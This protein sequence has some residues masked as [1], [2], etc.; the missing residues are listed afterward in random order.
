MHGGKIWVI[1]GYTY[2]GNDPKVVERRCLND[3]WYS[4]DGKNW[5]CATEAAPWSPRYRHR[6]LSYQGRMWI[7]GG[8]IGHTTESGKWDDGWEGD[9]WASV[10]GK[11]WDQALVSAPWAARSS[12]S[13]VV[14]DKAMWIFGGRNPQQS[15]SDVWRSTDGL[16]WTEI[17]AAA[18]WPVRYNH[19][20]VSWHDR[21]WLMGGLVGDQKKKAS[22]NDVWCSPPIED[23]ASLVVGSGRISDSHVRKITSQLIAM[24]QNNPL[25]DSLATRGIAKKMQ[26]EYVAYFHPTYS[27][28][29]AAY[30]Q[31]L[32]ATYTLVANITGW[33][34]AIVATCDGDQV[35]N[36][37]DP[38]DVF[39]A[40]ASDQ[41]CVFLFNN[42]MSTLLPELRNATVDLGA[43]GAIR[44]RVDPAKPALFSLR[45]AGLRTGTH[46]YPLVLLAADGKTL[47]NGTIKLTA[48]TPGRI[49]VCLR[50]EAS[51]DPTEAL[52]AVHSD[53]GSEFVPGTTPY[54]PHE[55]VVLRRPAPAGW[56]VNEDRLWAIRGEIDMLLPPG[57]VRII[58]SKGP[59]YRRVD[60]TIEVT[61]G[62]HLNRTLVLKRFTDMPAAGWYS[63]DDHCH[64]GGTPSRDEDIMDVLAAQDIHVTHVVQM[65]DVNGLYF[66]QSSW[67]DSSHRKRGSHLWS[68]GR[69][70][71][72][73][74]GAAMR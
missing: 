47:Y 21:L 54:Y 9:V 41:R 46:A 55:Q 49:T 67:A 68:A 7:I 26:G 72:V 43:G 61:E 33:K 19:T 57:P 10:N 13:A 6:V 4:T 14:H 20:T 25:Q 34:N 42:G 24:V 44:L 60:T 50:T 53:R 39:L 59:E 45:L 18:D 17:T 71:R 1:G 32:S 35:R 66:L 8:A 31:W 11:Q 62:E 37:R 28:R 74:G 27:D 64:I 73:P 30:S 2:P 5:T 65:G 70:T 48:V 52:L 36:I 22:R 23:E 16:Y 63:G 29:Q 69:K 12:H 58:A 38:Q 40:G 3:V 56:P 15:V 51:E